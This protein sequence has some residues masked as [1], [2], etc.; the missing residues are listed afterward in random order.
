M[1]T[2]QRKRQLITSCGNPYL[3]KI[4]LLTLFYCWI[5][6][7]LKCIRMK[8]SRYTPHRFS[9]HIIW[10]IGKKSLPFQKIQHRSVKILSHSL[11]PYYR[12]VR[13]NGVTMF[14]IVTVAPE[15][16]A[17]LE[18]RTM[19][20]FA[21]RAMPRLRQNVGIVG[22]RGAMGMRRRRLDVV[23]PLPPPGAAGSLAHSLAARR[24]VPVIVDPPTSFV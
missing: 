16:A 1:Q 6:P 17:P 22:N 24:P 10:I 5:F 12:N 9:T 14:R 19:I 2:V 11:P 13:Q 15:T 8:R 20:R 21:Y 3:V 18:L 23:V 7:I 4:K